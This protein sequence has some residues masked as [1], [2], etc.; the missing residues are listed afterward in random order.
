MA[1]R[2]NANFLNYAVFDKYFSAFQALEYVFADAYLDRVLDSE[3][4]DDAA[5]W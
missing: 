1:C 5:D 3:L 2:L 4:S